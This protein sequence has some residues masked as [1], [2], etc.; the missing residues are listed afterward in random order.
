MLEEIFTIVPFTQTRSKF[1]VVYSSSKQA[2]QFVTVDEGATNVFFADRRSWND[3][4]LTFEGQGYISENKHKNPKKKWEGLPII[5]TSNRIP[6]ILMPG[7][8]L[9]KECSYDHQAFMVRIKFHQ[10]LKENSNT[11]IFPYNVADLA[12]YIFDQYMKIGKALVDDQGLKDY[13]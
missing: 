5:I 11:T 6:D 4:K 1:D 7:H 8:K 10:L 3:S 9:A 12:T 2:P 13:K